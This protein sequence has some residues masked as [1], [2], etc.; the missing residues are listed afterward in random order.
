MFS[1]AALT[2]RRVAASSA[3]SQ[4]AIEILRLGIRCELCPRWLST[5]A[6]S[7]QGSNGL[8]DGCRR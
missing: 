3:T 7:Y 2:F 4:Q 8:V 5:V 6:G 1:R